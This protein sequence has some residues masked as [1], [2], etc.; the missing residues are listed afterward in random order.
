MLFTWKEEKLLKLFVLVEVETNKQKKIK[1][2][3][4]T[5]HERLKFP[6]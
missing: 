5:M 6:N 1:H 3:N 4:K 2:V